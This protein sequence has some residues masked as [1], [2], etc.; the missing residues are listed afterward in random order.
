MITDELLQA[1]QSR[2]KN[3]VH[4]LD[5]H[6]GLCLTSLEGKEATDDCSELLQ[7]LHQRDATIAELRESL[8]AAKS[9]S[10][11]YAR[12][13]AELLKPVAVEPDVGVEIIRKDRAS[14]DPDQEH[15]GW[16]YA[17]DSQGVLLRAYDA[18]AQS[19]ARASSA[20]EERELQLREALTDLQDWSRL[21]CGCNPCTGACYDNESLR[22]LLATV[23]R[24]A[25][26]ALAQP[27]PKE[28]PY[29]MRSFWSPCRKY[30]VTACVPSPGSEICIVDDNGD[31][32]E[33]TG[34]VQDMTL[35]SPTALSKHQEEHPDHD[36]LK[37]T[38][39]WIRHR[40]LAQPQQPDTS[41][42]EGRV[43]SDVVAAVVAMKQENQ[44]AI[45]AAD[46]EGKA[47]HALPEVDSDF[48]QR[49]IGRDEE[50]GN[51]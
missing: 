34:P 39:C 49:V 37:C 46:H 6:G 45:V 33:A 26:A 42:H 5:L 32:W 51:G 21:E 41:W 7:A 19:L 16:Q 30:I 1:I 3:R 18:A 2:Q 44:P 22:E 12:E 17:Y 20:H 10:A 35:I 31:R 13:N 28:P 40:G 25:G 15:P 4:I 38:I 23:H 43:D 29:Y 50:S 9:E 14:C 8:A 11:E 36:P 47:V 27:Q 48:L 24:V